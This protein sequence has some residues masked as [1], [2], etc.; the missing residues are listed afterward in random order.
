[1]EGERKG[2]EG[3]GAMKARMPEQGTITKNAKQSSVSQN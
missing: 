2:E 3:T 1:M